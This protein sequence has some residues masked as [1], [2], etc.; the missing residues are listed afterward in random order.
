MEGTQNG[1]RSYLITPIGRLQAVFSVL[2]LRSL[3]LVDG[4]EVSRDVLLEGLTNDPRPEVLRSYLSIYFSRSDP[5]L[6]SLP[7]DM[8]G[9]SDHMKRVIA[10]LSFLGFGTWT[11][12]SELSQRI[13]SPKGARAVGNAVGANPFL[14]VVPCHRVLAQG[15]GGKPGLGGFGAGLDVKGTLLRLEGHGDDIIGL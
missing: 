14:I 6:L 5:G 4:S 7:L 11:T 12:Y 9:L 8:T 1:L 3:S 13:G 2:G 15:K 10:E